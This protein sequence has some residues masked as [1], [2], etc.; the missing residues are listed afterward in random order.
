M[1]TPIVGA[2]LFTAVMAKAGWRCHC[3]G[4]CRQNHR[5]T[6][7][8]CPKWHDGNRVRLIAAPADPATPERAAAT[9]PAT[10]LRAWCP[11]C[12]T[13]AQRAA[14]RAQSATAASQGGLFDL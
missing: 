6:E 2:D 7:D 9:L 10:A 3:T 14:T 1:N 12:F 4:Q 11:P 8:R 13:A 5:R